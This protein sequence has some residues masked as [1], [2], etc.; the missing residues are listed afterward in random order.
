MT[1]TSAPARLTKAHPFVYR[2]QTA[3]RSFFDGHGNGK[4]FHFAVFKGFH[5]IKLHMED[6]L[7][8]TVSKLQ[9]LLCMNSKKYELP[10][11]GLAIE[12]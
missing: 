8:L 1:V 9:K 5:I 7:F 6:F 11:D 12:S 10:N 3:G 4:W 2:E